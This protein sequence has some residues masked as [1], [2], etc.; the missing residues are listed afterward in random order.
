MLRFSGEEDGF[1]SV[2]VAIVL[3][4][5][6]EFLLSGVVVVDAGRMCPRGPET[7]FG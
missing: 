7:R 3:L 2:A 6:P 1:D 5:V 4:G